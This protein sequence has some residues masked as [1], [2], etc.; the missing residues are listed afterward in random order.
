MTFRIRLVRPWANTHFEAGGATFSTDIATEE[1]DALLC[2]WDVTEAL[3]TFLGPSAWFTAEPRGNPGMGVLTHA[4]QV[5]AMARARPEQMLYPAHPDLRYRVP[6]VTHL[7]MQGRIPFTSFEGERIRKAAAAIEN[8]GGAIGS[9]RLRSS[10]RRQRR[11][12][13]S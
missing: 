2:E 11:R 1:A 12:R 8:N 5:E 13:G 10:R 6:H 3:Y 7:R 4:A 9:N